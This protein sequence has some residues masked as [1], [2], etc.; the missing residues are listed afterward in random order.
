MILRRIAN[1]IRRQDWFTVALEVVI[2]MIGIFLGLQVN[3]WNQSRVD[4]AEEAAFLEALYQDVLVLEKNSNRLIETRIE[5][6]NTIEAASNVLF[7]KVEWR[8]LTDD[9]CDA[10]STSHSP[11]IIATSLPSWT[12]LRDAGRTNILRNAELRRSLATLTQRR[13]SLD[14]IMEVAETQGYNLL[15]RH[16]DLFESQPFRTML[17]EAPERVHF[18]AK[19]RCN[20]EALSRDQAAMNGLASNMNRF[21]AV[22]NRFGIVPW[23]EQI[24]KIRIILEED[25]ET[26]D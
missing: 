16:P 19:S 6:L 14:R 26:G 15:Y 18:D 22:T 23:A 17:M 2:V 10:V 21:S 1:A 24:T 7:G 9:E 11:G 4:R 3:A 20:A 13:E 8:D 25:F 12:A 5:A